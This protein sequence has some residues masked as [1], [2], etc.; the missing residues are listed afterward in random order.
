M[1]QPRCMAV[2]TGVAEY[3]MC[4]RDSPTSQGTANPNSESLVALAISNGYC[5]D[6]WLSFQVNALDFISV[7]VWR[8][9]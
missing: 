1:V 8:C 3:Q 2:E 4:I 9:V 6:S 5:I 7:I